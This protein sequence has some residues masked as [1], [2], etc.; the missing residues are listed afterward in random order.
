MQ[1]CPHTCHLP[2]SCRGDFHA[3]TLEPNH[4]LKRWNIRWAHFWAALIV[5]KKKDLLREESLELYKTSSSGIF[6]QRQLYIWNL[7]P[8][9]DWEARNKRKRHAEM[10][11]GWDEMVRLWPNEIRM[12]PAWK[13]S[14]PPPTPHVFHRQRWWCGV[15]LAVCFLCAVCLWVCLCCC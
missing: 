8:D 13:L 9:D 12:P 2:W 5:K 10:W 15:G 1:P 3:A 11:V 14:C 6:R 7:G 4:F